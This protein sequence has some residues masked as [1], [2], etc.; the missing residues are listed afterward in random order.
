MF[1]GFFFVL[2]WNDRKVRNE[3]RSS[4]LLDAKMLV[5][6]CIVPLVF[7]DTTQ[8]QEVMG[9]MRFMQHAEAGVLYDRGGSS[10]AYYPDTLT[11]RPMLAR[12]T[13]LF[14]NGYLLVRESVVFKGDTLGTLCVRARLN[15]LYE[16]RRMLTGT[17]LTLM[18]ALFGLSFLLA[19]RLQRIVSRPILKLAE[20]TSAVSSNHDLSARITPES[21]D[22]VGA[23]YEQFNLLLER[24]QARE[25]ERNQAEEEIRSL[26]AQLEIKVRQRTE[27]LE[28]AN[29]ELESFSYSVS[30]DLRAPLRHVGGYVELLSRKCSAQMDEQARHY[31]Q[32]IAEASEHMGTLIDSLLRFSRT[33]RVELKPGLTDMNKLVQDALSMLQPEMQGRQIEWK[34]A[35]L[36]RVTGDYELLRQVWLNLLS[37]AIKYTRKRELAIIEVQYQENPSEYV[38]SVRDNGAGFD[39]KY[40]QKLFGVFQRLHAPED[41]EGTGI[42]LANVRQIIHRHQGRTWAEAELDKGAVFYFTLPK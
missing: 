42:G 22:E 40:A 13:S 23:L 1:S 24:L 15:A 29:K 8:A 33:G 10:F 17:L 34:I 38:F 18:L 26:N 12:D 37:N 19:Y 31:L 4:M 25:L 2:K 30:H 39:M 28:A 6:Y 32:S 7:G 41:F 5:D 27:M 16:S 3:I 11:A 14:T 35:T 9:R 21:R 36:P 20:W